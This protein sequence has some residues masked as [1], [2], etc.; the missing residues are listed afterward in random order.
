MRKTVNAPLATHIK[1]GGRTRRLPAVAAGEHN[2]PVGDNTP[3]DT[4]VGVAGVGMPP[5]RHREG[6]L[7]ESNAM[8]P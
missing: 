3:A 5:V 1:E 2:R 7:S 8:R 6:V 4:P